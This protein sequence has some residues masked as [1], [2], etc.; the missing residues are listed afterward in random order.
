MLKFVEVL[1]RQQ[2]ASIFF[3]M[4]LALLPVAFYL[5]L[6]LQEMPVSALVLMG[7][8]L[9]ILPYILL[10]TAGVIYRLGL[11]QVQLIAYERH[12]VSMSALVTVVASGSGALLC[13]LFGPEI[14]LG[15]H[16][17]F[18]LLYLLMMVGVRAVMLQVVLA[19]YRRARPRRRVLI[20]G[21]GNTGTQLAQA[22]RSHEGIDPV[23]FV[24]DNKS[25]Q[26]LRL[27]GLPVHSPAHIP[28]LVKA[29]DISRVLLAMPSQSQP[30]QA[31]I[32]QRMQKLG[33]EVQALPSFAQLIGEEA[34][35]EKLTPVPPQKFL[36][37][38]A[39]KLPL[40]GCASSY[41][42]RI[43]L[44]S[45]AGGSIGSEL[46]RQV[47]TCGPRK[48][49]LYELSE[50]ALY[51][52]HQELSQQLEGTGIELVPVLGSV[53]DPRQVRRVL[54]RHQVQVVLHAAAY[55][56]VPL[57]EANPLAGLANN[58]FGTQTLAR[59][60]AE[61]G[62]ERFILIS[63]DKA[64]RPTNVMGASKRMAE[65]IVQDLASR[66]GE[67]GDGTVGDTVFTM[68][69][70]GNVLG[71]SGSVIPLFQEQISRGGPV[72]V[73]DT[74]VKRYFMTIR[75]AVQLVLQAGA[76][77]RGG[78]VFVLDM[79]EPVSI[80]NLARQVIESAGYSVRDEDHPEGD[81]AIEIIGLRPGEKLEEE[82]TLSSE[83]TTTAHPKIFCARESV[84]SEIEVAALLRALRQAVAA[85][86]DAGAR[87]VILRWVEGY[88]QPQADR[89]TS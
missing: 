5:A 85:G 34:L 26:G 62:V 43:V 56:H 12:A 28:E 58:V 22:L 50:L 17:V 40:H 36:R 31:Q 64:V 23:A 69:R 4:D 19:L 18:G 74:R 67:L 11:S 2:K 72:T 88:V 30:K 78:E 41:E 70:F 3:T 51:T 80:L 59:A 61:F 27:V 73:T 29:G 76:E 87:Q 49:V 71:S 24:D 37:R 45:G 86:D 84:L 66:S 32:I 47:L 75:E 35:V 46:C 68:V 33:L 60:A 9:P 57:V 13:S 7:Q 79:G 44:V 48:L 42:D 82:L 83:L 20:Y 63:S 1:S 38:E 15:V 53:T 81:I 14:P 77:A 55:K 10:L 54:E 65:L 21:A 8:M 6:A 89:K 52:I 25:L 16:V 39:R